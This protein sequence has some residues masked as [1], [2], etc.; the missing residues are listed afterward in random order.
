MVGRVAEIAEL[1]ALLEVD[2][3]ADPFACMCTGDVGF[4]VRG[5][6][7][8]VLGVLTLHIGGG[9][10]WSRWS[11]QLPLLRAAELTEWLVVRGVV[12][13]GCSR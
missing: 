4:T 3:A 9:V 12:D 7:G 11:G 2:Q 6:R 1:A 13:P 5:E 8:A 10:D